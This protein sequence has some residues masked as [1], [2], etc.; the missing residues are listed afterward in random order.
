MAW[1]Q[2]FLRDEACRAVLSAWLP[3]IAA[4]AGT[5]RGA[6]LPAEMSRAERGYQLLTTKAFLPADF[7]QKVFDNLWKVWPAELREKAARAAP[8]ERRRMA[9]S[10]YGLMERPDG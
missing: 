5:A 2:P 10:R 8:D 3:L 6:D 1:R 9:F 7:D 4:V